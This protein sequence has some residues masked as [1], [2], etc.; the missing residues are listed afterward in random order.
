MKKFALI[1]A[2][3]HLTTAFA[4][5]DERVS[6]SEED[7]NKIKA[8]HKAKFGS[9]LTLEALEFDGDGYA[10]L[11]ESE[12]VNIEAALN[13]AV[14]AG[15]SG[16]S[17]P[18]ATD[19][20]A[21]V[22]ATEFA[23]LQT[24]MAAVIENNNTLTAQVAAL[25]EETE[26]VEAVVIK[27]GG[28]TVIQPKSQDWDKADAVRPWNIR[29]Q[30]QAQGISA[31]DLGFSIKAAS[32]TD[33]SKIISDLG[34]YYRTRFQEDIISFITEMDDLRKL[35]PMRSNVQ[36]EAILVNAFLGEFS[37][38]FQDEF[39]PKGSFAFEPE[40]VKMYDV[41]FD[42]KF[43]KMKEMEKTWL[44]YLN[45][46]GSDALKMPFVKYLM[47][48]T[49]KKLFNEQQVRRISGV[50]VEPTDG[51]AG[52]SINAANGLRKLVRTKITEN[53]LKP[54]VLG[55][56]TDVNVVDKVHEGAR[57]IPEHIRNSGQLLC[58]VPEDI[59][60]MYF[61][62]LETLHGS[63]VDYK[64]GETT[65]KFMSNIKLVAIPNMGSSQRI[66]YTF[67]GNIVLCED[68]PGEMFKFNYESE[69]R[70][71]KTWSDWK[72]SIAIVAVG[73]KWDDLADADYEHQMIW[74]SDVDLPASYFI[75]MF[76]DDATPS[77]ADHTSLVSVAN[78]AATA[79]TDIDDMTVGQT[80]ILKCGSDTNAITIAKAGN[81]A[82]ITA[83]WTPEKDDTITLYK[84]AAADIIELGRTTSSTDA[85]VIAVDDATPDV[86]AGTVFITSAN[87]GATAIT[88]LDNPVVGE[89][90]TI[91]GGSDTHSTTIANSGNFALS[92]AMT[93]SLGSY[94]ELYV[95]ADNDYVELSRG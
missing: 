69:D 81:F 50:Y 63:Q 32:S 12:L 45:T 29:A 3:L 26:V 49:M 4:F 71:L 90:Y 83:A 34:D 73:K 9:E 22:S 47:Q 72:E 21:G 11:H 64:A 92:A 31:E 70:T 1:Y 39:T 33:Y 10:T 53:K 61:K 42:H 95:R 25:S 58:Y 48:E 78:E 38:S 18:E 37:Q 36:D 54:F 94:I 2:A 14:P 15:D 91:H 60:Y 57:L 86:A 77:V 27:T 5:T 62:R 30:A 20:P 55:E 46:S 85:L 75:S 17:K 56:I 40:K 35:F 76:P 51:T 59:L 82:N 52:P 68:G 43:S 67:H 23:E 89:T 6:L 65:L 84:R 28:K 24:Q 41:K 8:A 7:V 79:I 16:A 87:T 74:V 93:L 44:G 80:V 66:I 13:K 19:P 88:D